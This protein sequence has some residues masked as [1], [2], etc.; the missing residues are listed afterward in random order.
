MEILTELL[1]SQPLSNIEKWNLEELAKI[2]EGY[3][4]QKVKELT[5]SMPIFKDSYGNIVKH[6]DTVFIEKCYGFSPNEKKEFTLTWDSNYGMYKYGVSDKS[7]GHPFFGVVRFK[8]V[9]N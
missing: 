8:L 7:T 2:T 1:A 3:V 4:E 9:N 6:G 5:N